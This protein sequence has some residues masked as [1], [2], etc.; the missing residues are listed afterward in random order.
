MRGPLRVN[1]RLVNRHVQVPVTPTWELFLGKHESTVSNGLDHSAALPPRASHLRSSII[2]ETEPSCHVCVPSS[3]K[4]TLRRRED[5]YNRIESW[6][7]CPPVISR[8]ISFWMSS[9][10]TRQTP[11]QPLSVRLYPGS[12]QTAIA[13]RGTSVSLVFGLYAARLRPPDVRHFVNRQAETLAPRVKASSPGFRGSGR[14]CIVLLTGGSW[15]AAS[16]KNQ[17]QR[18]T[19]R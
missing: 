19:Q 6:S 12:V 13:S 1:K 7:F 5:Q 10:F 4:P 8:K 14:A 2:F 16:P 9:P 17:C 15:A 18:G 3:N 11:D